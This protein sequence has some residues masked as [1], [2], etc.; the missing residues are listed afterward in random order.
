[1]ALFCFNYPPPAPP[2]YV[3]NHR[4]WHIWREKGSLPHWIQMSK[5]A[6]KESFTSESHLNPKWYCST[7]CMPGSIPISRIN[8]TW[9][10]IIIKVITF[11]ILYCALRVLDIKEVSFHFWIKPPLL[12]CFGG[13]FFLSNFKHAMFAYEFYGKPLRNMAFE[14]LQQALF[15][16][17]MQSLLFQ[18]KISQYS[19]VWNIRPDG[20]NDPITT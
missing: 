2:S 5:T 3:Q 12:Q 15:C 20:I 7:A 16:I 8:D 1:M 18:L 10:V 17:D 19:L 13:R 9:S 14:S 4:L 6:E 11:W